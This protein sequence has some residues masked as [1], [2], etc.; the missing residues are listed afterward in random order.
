MAWHSQQT[1]DDLYHRSVYQ[2]SAKLDGFAQGV[3]LVTGSDRPS[4]GAVTTCAPS[5]TAAPN[6]MPSPFARRQDFDC[7][8]IND[9][10]EAPKP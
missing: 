9:A 3:D 8:S 5:Q 7:G 4:A 2:M 10:M 1:P 6:G